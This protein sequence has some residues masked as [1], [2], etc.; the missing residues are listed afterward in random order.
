MQFVTGTFCSGTILLLVSAVSGLILLL[1]KVKESEFRRLFFSAGFTAFLVIFVFVSVWDF[2]RHFTDY[3]EFWHWGMMI[4]ESLR[5]DRFYC[6]PQSRMVIHKDYPPFLCMLEVFFSILGGYSEGLV[7]ASVHLFMLSV[8]V[9]PCAEIMPRGNLKRF[10]KYLSSI[11]QSIIWLL[12]TFFSI[13]LFDNAGISKTILAD[14]P[15]A[16]V[17]AYG[18]YLIISEKA[19]FDLFYG[20]SFILTLTALVNIKQVG[21]AMVGVLSL[22]A[23]TMMLSDKQL[24]SKRSYMTIAGAI[25]LSMGSLFVWNS[26]VKTQNI[27]DLRSSA[28]GEGQ[29]ALSKIDPQT[30]IRCLLHHNPGEQQETLWRLVQ[31]LFTRK[32]DTGLLPVSYFI[33]AL[34]MTLVI[35]FLTRKEHISGQKTAAVI[36]TFI[37]GSLGYAFMLSALFIFC[38]TPDE[39]QELRG[40]ERYVDSYVLGEFLTLEMMLLLI[41]SKEMTGDS[42]SLISNNLKRTTL[43]LFIIAGLTLSF[44]WLIPQGLQKDPYQKYRL[45]A[46]QIHDTTQPDSEIL[47]VYDASSMNTWFGYIQMFVYYLDNDRTFPLSPDL[48]T[49]NLNDSQQVLTAE[50]TI[51]NYNYIYI[52]NSN[53]TVSN[54]LQQHVVENRKVGAGETYQIHDASETLSFSLTSVN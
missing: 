52:V 6:V 2:Q 34:L 54:W 40:Y 41:E 9:L 42:T 20:L 21:I 16:C 36:L 27:Q 10:P 50:Q 14:I 28:G 1:R 37:V 4:K 32:I 35:L 47:L 17:F 33:F 25:F 53:D 18:T 5:L 15:L 51:R 45:M 8:I 44:D 30:Y 11:F 39:M 48:Y 38:F 46:E 24:R 49:V 7:S 29:F 26:Y 12:L 31:A 19:F 3:D 23:V 43:A 13:V 22:L